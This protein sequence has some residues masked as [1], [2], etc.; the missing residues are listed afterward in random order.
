MA[1]DVRTG[2]VV[3]SAAAAPVALDSPLLPLS[4]TKL[5][6]AAI[7]WEHSPCP[8]AE[9]LIVSGS[10]SAGRIMALTLRDQ[11]GTR[12]VLD[13]L[14]RFGFA[15]PSVTLSAD[16][17]NAEWGDALSIGESGFSVTILEISRFL[18]AVGNDGGRMMKRETARHLQLAMLGTVERG[19]AKGVRDRVRPATWK[20]GG[21]TGTGPAQA[22]PYDGWFAGLIFGPDGRP[23]YTIATFIKER[24]LGGG[25]AAEVSADMASYLATSPGKK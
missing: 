17:S 10:D 14:R 18:E 5:W 25:V 6:L 1:L 16:S 21:K 8:E 3:A 13:E 11:I 23:R 24:G 20:I 9:E 15:A 2:A 22:K 7:C 4:L 12:G 19:T